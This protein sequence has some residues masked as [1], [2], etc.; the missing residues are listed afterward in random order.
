MDSLNSK[1]YLSGYLKTATFA[2]L[3]VPSPAILPFSPHPEAGRQSHHQESAMSSGWCCKM[4][5]PSRYAWLIQCAFQ[6]SP[7]VLERYHCRQSPLREFSILALVSLSFSLNPVRSC[8]VRVAARV[9]Q[10]PATS[11]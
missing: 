2:F 7:Q 1:I 8:S 9:V 10:C 3:P 5:P 6:P 11:V 4:A